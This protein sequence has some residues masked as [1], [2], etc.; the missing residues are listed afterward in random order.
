MKDATMI[1]NA[2]DLH[3][4]SSLLTAGGNCPL[5]FYMNRRLL[6]RQ[7]FASD[8]H[9]ADCKTTMGISGPCRSRPK[10]VD[11]EGGPALVCEA[12]RN[13]EFYET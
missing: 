8:R 7:L 5:G 6:A 3:T 11:S 13:C 1:G 10:L 2:V 12:C 9:C 4:H